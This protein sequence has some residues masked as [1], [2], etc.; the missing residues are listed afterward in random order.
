MTPLALGALAASLTLLAAPSLASPAVGTPP[1]A[2]AQTESGPP[3]P[4]QWPV[5]PSAI[6]TGF[7]D[8]KP[9]AAGHRG[10]DI[11]A[12]VGQVVVAARA[13]TV[14][15]AGPVAGRPVV[16]LEHPGGTLTTYLPV[17]PVVRVGERVQA[18][19]PIGTVAGV[20]H[21]LSTTC[22]HWGARRQGQYID[23][24]T[25]LPPQAGLIVLLPD[26][27]D[28]SFGTRSFDP[29]ERIGS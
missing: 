8:P 9:Y 1:R 24:R 16:V 28:G 6:V 10:I 11:S 18:G 2:R 15:V 29:R 25:L 17:V 12:T 3:Q 13:G 14:T 5:P 20:G 4:G 21:C 7:D 27:A 19:D 23:P 22:L 26:E